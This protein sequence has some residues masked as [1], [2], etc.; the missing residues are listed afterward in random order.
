M[1]ETG[2]L[3]AEKTE[4]FRVLEDMPG[5]AFNWDAISEVLVHYKSSLYWLAIILVAIFVLLTQLGFFP[6]FYR[7]LKIQAPG[8]MRLAYLM[9]L[10]VAIIVFHYWLWHF[11]FVALLH[12]YW[13]WLAWGII[14]LAWG[15]LVFWTPRKRQV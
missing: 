8:S 11:I 15:G 3:S 2:G 1:E 7:V 12:N 13:L 9:S 6:F 5:W 4:L 10:L 14:V